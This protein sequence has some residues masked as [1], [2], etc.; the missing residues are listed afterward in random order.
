MI[1]AY[2]SLFLLFVM[3]KNDTR[4]SSVQSESDLLNI[5]FFAFFLLSEIAQ[6]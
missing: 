4:E 3:E 6:K 1:Y 5:L 2:L